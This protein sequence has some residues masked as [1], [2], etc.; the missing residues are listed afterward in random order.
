MPILHLCNCLHGRFRVHT[1]GRV[2]GE[3]LHNH[4]LLWEQ[5][6]DGCIS[7]LDE[8][9]CIFKLLAGTTVNLFN[10]LA[11]LAGNVSGVAIQHGG[12]T[13]GDLTGVIQD[14]DLWKHFDLELPN[15]NFTQKLEAILVHN[16]DLGVEGV[17]S[18]GWVVL[19]VSSH[20]S[21]T[22]FLDRHVLDVESNVVTGHGFEQRLVVHLH[23][24]YLGG[25]VAGSEGDDHAGLDDAGLNTTNGYCSNT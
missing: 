12:V 6:D 5:F 1:E 3:G 9:G 7:S 11:E 18:L 16:P 22:D 13:L 4:G 2:A 24:L 25:Q 19:A 20:V 17:S 15:C 21:T 14:D 23:G 10:E 8:L